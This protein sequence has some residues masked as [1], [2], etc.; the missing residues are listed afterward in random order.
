MRR[1]RLTT[2][3][4]QI[5]GK[6]FTKTNPP[7]LSGLIGDTPLVT[8]ANTTRKMMS[9][10]AVATKMQSPDLKR[11]AVIVD[12]WSEERQAFDSAYCPTARVTAVETFEWMPDELFLL[13]S[14]DGPARETAKAGSKPSN[15]MS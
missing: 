8:I 1:E 11:L 4:W 9:Q 10:R 3:S 14:L 12:E 5:T 2:S 7:P 6:G 15:W 13:H